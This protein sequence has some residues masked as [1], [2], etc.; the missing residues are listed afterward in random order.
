[1]E[2]VIIALGSNVGNR[3]RHLQEG[4]EFLTRL[5]EVKP[6]RS[7]IY[8]TEPV[9]P[10]TRYFL[11]AAFQVTTDLQPHTLIKKLKQFEHEHGRSSKY[12]HM[13]P[14]TIDLDI[15]SYGNLVIHGEKLIIPH[16]EYE[17]RLFVLIP[18]Q[19]IAPNCTDPQSG[20]VCNK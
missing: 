18:M 4:G 14:R 19:D 8:L 20:K 13:K 7:A 11:N 15:I 12:S 6:E 10:P 9:G 17:K 2:A 16:P 3:H 1:M 5:S